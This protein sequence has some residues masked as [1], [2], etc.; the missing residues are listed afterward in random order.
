[1]KIKYLLFIGLLLCFSCNNWLDITPK[2]QTSK[3]D[4]F[5]DTQGYN[6]ALAGVYYILS[7]NSLYGRSLS[8]GE[9]D[10]LAQYWNVSNR[11]GHRYYPL[12]TYDYKH[13]TSESLLKDFWSKLYISITNANLIIENIR[14]KEYD[15]ETPELIEGEALALR[16]FAHLEVYRLFGP[17][18]KTK[19]DLQKESIPYRDKYDV[20]VR[21]PESCEKV[22]NYIKEDLLDALALFEKDPI[23][24]YGRRYDGN[25]S[26]IR[27]NNVLN[28]RGTRMNYYA[29]KGL[30]ARV[31]QCLHNPEEAY[32]YSSSVIDEVAN[33]ELFPFVDIQSLETASGALKDLAFSTEHLFSLNVDSLYETTKGVFGHSGGK[34]VEPSYTISKS[35]YL[36][37]QNNIY[38]RKPDGLSTDIRLR[39]WF[40]TTVEGGSYYYIT[41][42]AS[43]GVVSGMGRGYDQEVPMITLA[44]MYFIACEAQIGKDNGLALK[45]L[46]RMREARGLTKLVDSFSD[47]VLLDY[48]IREARRE[49]IGSGQMFY[50]YK[51]LFAP[52]Y[53]A[54]KRIIEP[55]EDIFELPIPVEEKEFS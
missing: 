31:E 40:D 51:R 29:V 15:I 44:E 36:N 39:Y 12:S 25:S 17:V 47:E 14:K 48:L 37:I 32:K 21:K 5:S 30:L 45:Y 13:F 6:K 42:L 34:T 55:S 53:I 16:A 9:L 50:M 20:K 28:H 1:M 52:I 38:T 49:F 23:R 41:K 11:I 22:L 26:D 54:E 18:V 4:M 43:A 35:D 33:N 19:V 2:G 3:E 24:E 46:N 8:F 7:D 10:L 27:Y